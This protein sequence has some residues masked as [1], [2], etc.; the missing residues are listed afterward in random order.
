MKNALIATIALSG[1]A[2][3][4]IACTTG[5]DEDLA[6]DESAVAPNP[7]GNGVRDVGEQ[8]DDGNNKN[9]DGCSSTCQLEQVHRL[10]AIDMQVNT[11]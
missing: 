7:C 11:D 2:M 1:L 6:S 8:C 4:M 3:S 9:L 10:N 5:T